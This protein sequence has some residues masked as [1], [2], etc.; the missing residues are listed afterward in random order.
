MRP[1]INLPRV[2]QTRENAVPLVGPRAVRD[3]NPE[4]LPGDLDVAAARPEVRAG[5]LEEDRAEEAHAQRSDPEEKGTHAAIYLEEHGEN[6][7]RI[8]PAERRST[9]RQENT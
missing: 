5:C 1:N 4:E 3:R 6:V 8:R 2:P 9:L 7:L